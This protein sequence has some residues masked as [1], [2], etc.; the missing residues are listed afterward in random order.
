MKKV[1]N[2][3]SRLEHKKR[4]GEIES[5]KKKIETIL[6]IVQCASCRF[7]CAMCG[8]HLNDTEKADHKTSHPLDLHLCESCRSE[9]E[10]FL[11]TETGK[12]VS[13]IFWHN[14]E[15][16][17]LWSAWFEY[18]KAIKAFRHSRAFHNLTES[19]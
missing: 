5:H 19:T 7:K 9:F 8:F 14:E 11:E 17:R 6:R 10:D 2:I 4:Q 18:Q 1:L 16:K 12:P 15:W 13:D 3:T